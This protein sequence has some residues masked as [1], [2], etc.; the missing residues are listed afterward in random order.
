M[1]KKLQRKFIIAAGSSL[2]AV[3]ILILGIT[4]SINY[5]SLTRRSDQILSLLAENDGK[6]P[7][8]AMEPPAAG[9]KKPVSDETA[10]PQKDRRFVEIPFE[11]RYFSV[12]FGENGSIRSIDTGKVAAVDSALAKKY[13][14]T[15][16]QNGRRSGFLKN[17][18]FLSQKVDDGAT[19][20][21]FLDQRRELEQFS[22]FLAASIIVSLTG[23][24]L[25]LLL[26]C[27]V[28]ERIV[29]PVIEGYEK[30]KHFITD[31]GHE[32]K[33]PL[34][35]ID[36]DVAVLEMEK[37]ED[38][39]TADIKKQ[40]NRLALLTANLI[41][42]AKLEEQQGQMTLVPVNVSA[43]LEK[44]LASFEAPARS[45]DLTIWPD[46]SSGLSVVGGVRELESLFHLLLD[47]AIT[48]CPPQD[49]ID[50]SLKQSKK[51]VVFEITNTAPNLS[52][53]Q[54]S[55]LFERFYKTDAS[56][57]KR[58]AGG[59]GFGIGLAVVKAIAEAH[60]GYADATLHEADGRQRLTIGVF[61]HTMAK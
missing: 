1:I 38:E 12:L 34:A 60:K 29:R 3:L 44:T 28:S 49:E 21:I 36:A 55:G 17:Y 30:Q 54:L 50:I 56:R 20:I 51:G 2:L 6:F 42:L 27:L 11:S 46:I 8:T 31:A 10:P 57:E 25:V 59:G 5:I 61:I 47:N 39:W 58:E 15:I 33:T 48:H 13:A 7:D 32:L 40:T 26:L 4:L 23:L 41:Y 19:R 14:E 9:S 53:E 37:G 18:R 43:L 16:F 35:I 22:D 52:R 24:V 45:R